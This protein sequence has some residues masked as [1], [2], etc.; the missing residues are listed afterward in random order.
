MYG[1]LNITTYHNTAT[2]AKQSTKYTCNSERIE[3]K[4]CSSAKKGQINSV[5]LW[6]VDDGKM[7]GFK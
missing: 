5:L 7:H 6:L 1:S 2:S 4:T 3:I